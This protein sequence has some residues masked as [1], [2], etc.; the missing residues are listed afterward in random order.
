MTIHTYYHTGMS[1]A[2]I[3]PAVSFCIERCTVHYCA[4]FFFFFYKLFFLLCSCLLFVLSIACY[5]FSE[6]QTTTTTTSTTTTAATTTT[7]TTRTTTTTKQQI[8]CMNWISFFAFAAV[9]CLLLLL[10][11]LR[12]GGRGGGGGWHCCVNIY[13]SYESNRPLH[14][15]PLP[16]VSSAP[17]WESGK[18][19]EK[20]AAAECNSTLDLLPED[21]SLSCFGEGKLHTKVK[22][23]RLPFLFVCFLCKGTCTNWVY[24]NTMETLWQRRSVIGRC[25][26]TRRRMHCTCVLMPQRNWFPSAAAAVKQGK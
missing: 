20:M 3:T 13:T 11:F 15:A 8:L 19:P 5:R 21:L 4:L 24:P 17:F 12:G 26:R 6:I 10:L 25:G 16:A 23:A 22:T 14:N 1:I 2:E 18:R 7:T 9:G